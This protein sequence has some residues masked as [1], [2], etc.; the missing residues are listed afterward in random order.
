M[1]T[2]GALFGLL[3]SL[4]IL[5][6]CNGKKEAPPPPPSQNQ[7]AAPAAAPVPPGMEAENPAEKEGQ[8]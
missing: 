3:I 8:P 1:T 4:G 5:A 6:G 7:V 2:R